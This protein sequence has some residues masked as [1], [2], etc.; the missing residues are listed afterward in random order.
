MGRGQPT[1]YKEDYC[2]GII[3]FMKDGRHVV[4][5]AAEIGVSK[6]TI[7]EWAKVYPEFKESMDIAM[8]ACEAWYVGKSREGMLGN[9]DNWNPTTYIFKMKNCFKW[10]DKHD[11]EETRDNYIINFGYNPEKE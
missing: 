10:R 7:Y 3:L 4:E 9:I 2:D 6:D 1:K 11:G 8:T 5:Y